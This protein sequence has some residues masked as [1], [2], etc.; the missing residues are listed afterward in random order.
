MN[1]KYYV[2]CICDNCF[3]R[4]C[5]YE[6][7]GKC[8]YCKHYTAPFC[9]YRS[10]LDYIS[11][12]PYFEDIPDEPQTEPLVHI[13]AIIEGYTTEDIFGEWCVAEKVPKTG[14]FDYAIWHTTGDFS[15]V[16]GGAYFKTQ[17]ERAQYIYDNIVNAW[18]RGDF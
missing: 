5:W 10:E 9:K 12:C 6:S 13:G 3:N 17:K 18:G 11:E 14:G 15:G 7:C 8:K 1:Y 4:R 16:Y 2:A